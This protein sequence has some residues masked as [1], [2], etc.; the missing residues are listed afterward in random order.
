MGREPLG[1]SATLD[2]VR[3][4]LDSE[5]PDVVKLV[6]ERSEGN[7]FY[8]GELA[9]SYLEHGSL[10]RLPD[11]VQGTVLARLDLLPAIESRVLHRRSLL[12]RAFRA[13]GARPL[14]PRPAQHPP[15]PR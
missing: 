9:R 11:T 5:E 6:A 4:L 12:G 15:P 10:E 8:A 7:P 13:S 3:C 1:S 2:L 14:P